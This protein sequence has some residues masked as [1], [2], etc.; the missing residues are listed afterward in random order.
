MHEVKFEGHRFL[1][2]RTRARVSVVQPNVPATHIRTLSLRICVRLTRN[3]GQLDPRSVDQLA[4]APAFVLQVVTE[5]VK[6][7]EGGMYRSL[8]GGGRGS[9]VLAEIIGEHRSLNDAAFA[10]R[11][12]VSHFAPLPLNSS[13]VS[14]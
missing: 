14:R 8:R 6:L 9:L 5:T 11:D 12:D 1:L 2:S 10:K 13:E 7:R 3:L 4:K